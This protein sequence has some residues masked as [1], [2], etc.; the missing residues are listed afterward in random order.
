MD[1]FLQGVGYTT[2]VRVL[3]G[4]AARV[5]H[6]YYGRGKR[7]ATG[8]VVGT[9]TAIGQGVALACGDNPTKVTGS[10]K[11]LPQLSQIYDRWCKEDPPT[12]KQLLVEADVPELLAEKGCNGNTT[13][14]EWAVG[15]LSLIAF[16]YLLRIGEYMIK[17]K[18]NKTKQM[19]QFKYEDVTFFKKNAAGNLW[20]VFLEVHL[21]TSSQRQTAQQ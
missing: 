12:T 5:R 19:V 15:N 11:L 17:K 16:Y 13:E 10:K 2:K 21:H 6:G 7:I 18:Q 1:P 14:L 20:C 4:F 8:T 9:L 3:T